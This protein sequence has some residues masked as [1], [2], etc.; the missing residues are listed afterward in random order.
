MHEV[1]DLVRAETGVELVAETR[2]VGFDEED[3]S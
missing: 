1:R 2:L 3:P